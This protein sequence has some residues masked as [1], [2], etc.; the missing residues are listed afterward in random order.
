MCNRCDNVKPAKFFSN[1][2]Q[3]QLKAKMTK[4]KKLNPA[5]RAEVSCRSCTNGQRCEEKCT[6]CHEWKDIDKFS[7]Q[8]R[9]EE[10]PVSI[11]SPFIRL[12]LLT[13]VVE[14][15]PMPGGDQQHGGKRRR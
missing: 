9:K 4:N 14:L 1:T 7:N 3:G 6:W 10:E 2:K 11:V 15:Y 8:Q 12:H 5:T 13:Q